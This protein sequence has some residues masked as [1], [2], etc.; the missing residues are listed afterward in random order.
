MRR[1]YNY[2]V[3]LTVRHADGTISRTK[4][5]PVRASSEERAVTAL[6]EAI[7]RETQKR[8]T[9]ITFQKVTF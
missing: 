5:V 4:A 1:Q 7:E 9:E 8:V 6:T 3:V 2:R